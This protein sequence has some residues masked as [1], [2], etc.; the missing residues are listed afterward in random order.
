MLW[1]AAK[2]E[3]YVC[4][5]RPPYRAKARFIQLDRPGC[6]VC[7]NLKIVSRRGQIY[8]YIYMYIY[9][10]IYKHI[11]FFLMTLKITI[12]VIIF[13][14]KSSEI[15]EQVLMGFANIDR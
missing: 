13:V 6:K 3:V 9:I 1:C 7:S 5:I 8:I 15:S 10:Y 11:F 2:F 12:E 14:F 4:E